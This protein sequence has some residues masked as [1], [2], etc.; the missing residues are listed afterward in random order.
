MESAFTGTSALLEKLEQQHII[1]PAEHSLLRKYIVDEATDDASWPKET[2]KFLEE[3]IQHFTK[4]KGVAYKPIVIDDLPLWM[5]EN[6]A[7]FLILIAHHT[8]ERKRVM[9]FITLRIYEHL[10][11][12]TSLTN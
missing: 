8:R 2:P 1:F 7:N 12:V 3:E 11:P 10:S 9:I 6:F 4:N 5:Q